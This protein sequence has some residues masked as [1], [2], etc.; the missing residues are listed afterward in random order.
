MDDRKPIWLG[1][2]R[3]AIAIVRVSSKKQ[4]DN[5]SPGVQ[6]EG[7]SA[8]SRGVGLELVRVEE[9]HESAKRSKD[10]RKFHALL[11]RAR[12]EK[13]GHLIFWVWDRTTRN[14]TDA[15]IMEED[16][17]DGVFVVHV[18]HEHKVLHRDSSESDWL[19]AD[20]NTLTAKQYS[21][22]LRRR[23]IESMTAKAEK[24]WYP[25]V[26][27][28]AYLNTRDK[29]QPIAL[30][31]W[32]RDVVRSMALDLRVKQ[33]LSLE[34]IAEAMRADARIPARSRSRFRGVG[35]KEAVSRILND[36]I[37]RGDFVWREKQYTGKHEAVFSRE[38]W[39]A[40]QATFGQ[41]ASQRT[42]RAEGLFSRPDLRLHCAV[43][44]CLVVFEPKR[45][46]EREYRYYH[47]TNGRKQHVG[48]IANI[49]E[50]SILDQL[51]SAV[52]AISLTEDLAAAIADALSATH[53]RAQ[54]MKAQEVARFKTTLADLDE[55]EDRLYDR[56]DA[57]AIDSEAYRRQR[58][59][60]R[61]ERDA[62]SMKL[63]DADVETDGAYL[64]TARRVLELSK[65][66]KRLWESRSH[67]E[68]RDLLAKVLQNP[69]L[70]GRSVRYDLKKPFRVLS[71]MR[72]NEKWRGGRDSNS[73][74]TSKKVT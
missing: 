49:T 60:L 33:G 29:D 65:S 18:A 24:G 44:G 74:S 12:Q 25:T 21:R 38:E 36:V 51:G 2:N 63:R 66:A 31:D 11:E 40:I 17:R 41:R 72:G 50:D 7:I 53:R 3:R 22:D 73:S 39:E 52:D 34:A 55:K 48:S 43:C 23:S 71:E 5:N 57:G 67:E 6:R 19:T 56:L 68:R 16:V 42:H 46:R 15:E 26:A 27:P 8:Y 28:F 13:I 14:A 37:Y 32:G 1:T 59:R 47:C 54:A 69:L 9:F 35:R 70:D 10:R 45:K 62:L 61:A 4:R 64:V 30:A 20:F 58:E